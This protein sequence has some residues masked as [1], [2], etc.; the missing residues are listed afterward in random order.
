MSAAA[1][2]DIEIEI[3]YEDGFNLVIDHLLW[4]LVTLSCLALTINWSQLA[5]TG[6]IILIINDT[7]IKAPAIPS[8]ISGLTL[9]PLVSSSK[10]LS[11]PALD[12]GRGAFF[13]LLIIESVK[14]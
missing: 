13:F 14:M 1:A 6:K 3:L 11:R 8:T 10:N 4:I 12:A 5:Y 9:N 7:P 2:N